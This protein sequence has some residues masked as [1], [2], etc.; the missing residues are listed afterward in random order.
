MKHNYFDVLINKPINYWIINQNFRYH[1]YKVDAEN[2]Y[3][4]FYSR[5][6]FY[7]LNDE[8]GLYD[9]KIIML[10]SHSVTR[11]LHCAGITFTLQ[12]YLYTRPYIQE[13]DNP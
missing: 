3:N 9:S 2:N 10:C 7:Q 6:H 5:Y 4:N 13:K 1:S 12:L 11:M 8:L